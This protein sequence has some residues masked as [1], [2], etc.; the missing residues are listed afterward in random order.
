[1][2]GSRLNPCSITTSIASATAEV[3][4]HGD[5]VGPRHHDLADDG[6][7]ELD[8]RLDELALLVLDHVFLDRDVGEREQL[9]L[10]DERPLLQALAGEDHVGEPDEPRATPSGAAG[11]A[12]SAATG[13]ADEQRGPLG[14]LERPRL[15][16][17]LGERRT[18][19]PR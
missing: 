4:G 2:T 16:R 12:T 3:A 14:V 5:H 1:M 6:V 10:G 7:A 15:R 19:S 9:L 17:R 18:R 11:S 8:D 13:R